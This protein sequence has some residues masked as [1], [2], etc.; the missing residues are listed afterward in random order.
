MR[1]H[2]FDSTHRMDHIIEWRIFANFPFQ[3]A[4]R[5]GTVRTQNEAAPSNEAFAYQVHPCPRSRKET[6]PVNV[7]ACSGDRTARG[8][9]Y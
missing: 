9:E 8:G 2:R 5:H 6:E 7:R 3:K 4:V 1:S